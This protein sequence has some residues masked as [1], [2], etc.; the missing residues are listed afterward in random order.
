MVGKSTGSH[1]AVNTDDLS[2]SFEIPAQNPQGGPYFTSFLLYNELTFT[3]LFDGDIRAYDH[4]GHQQFNSG[5]NPFYVPQLL[6][7]KNDYLFAEMIS[8][9]TGQFFLAT[10]F[11]P[12]G[13]TKQQLNIDFDIV[14]I[15]EFSTDEL[16][17]FGNKNGNT[18]VYKYSISNNGA[19]LIRDFGPRILYKSFESSPDQYLL[20]TA[21][22]LF[23]YIYSNGSSFAVGSFPV[24]DIKSDD[25]S[26][27]LYCSSANEVHLLDDVSLVEE[28]IIHSS[29][30]ILSVNIL[31]NK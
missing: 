9:L 10:L 14:S 18:V 3:G 6:F 11:Y 1:L 20:A 31:Y 8:P 26:H 29:D 23:K 5:S 28:G 4:T 13:I 30:S 7:R 25:V 16:L 21:S 12:G 19:T 22:G 27:K 17:L 24:Y 15:C 2:S